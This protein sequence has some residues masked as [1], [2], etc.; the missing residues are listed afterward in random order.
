[1]HNLDA[2]GFGQAP[3]PELETAV[4]RCRA[5]IETLEEFAASVRAIRRGTHTP[6]ADVRLR[7]MVRL[8]SET[9]EILRRQLTALEAELRQPPPTAPRPPDNAS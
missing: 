6:G 3:R 4:L 7:E 8:N 1:M 2:H 5:A 9:V